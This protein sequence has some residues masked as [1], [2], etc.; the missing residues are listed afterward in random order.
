LA[1]G[2]K[3]AAEQELSNCF[4]IERVFFFFGFT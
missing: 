4:L 3:L 2:A 1:A